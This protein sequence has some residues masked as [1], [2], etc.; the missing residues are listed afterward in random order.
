MS[1]QS[2]V[3]EVCG[4]GFYA[5]VCKRGLY[6]YEARCDWIFC[7]DELQRANQTLDHFSRASAD[8]EEVR[9]VVVLTLSK[10]PTDPSLVGT[11]SGALLQ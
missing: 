5:H 3:L 10:L 11:R 9:T 4:S 7:Q 2:A 1:A 6:A 8:L